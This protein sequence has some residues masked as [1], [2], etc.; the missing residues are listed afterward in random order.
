MMEEG[1]TAA[2]AAAMAVARTVHPTNDVGKLPTQP[3]QRPTCHLQ[4]G[5]AKRLFKALG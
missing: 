1:Q 3:I 2:C 5:H 4:S